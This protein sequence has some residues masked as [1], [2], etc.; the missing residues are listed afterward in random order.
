MASIL[1]T[2][3][4]NPDSYF[5]TFTFGTVLLHFK[6]LVFKEWLDSWLVKQL[7][8]GSENRSLELDLDNPSERKRLTKR[9]F[10]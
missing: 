4:I 5:S 10:S 7:T 6:L 3:S 1:T 8:I 2:R 9:L